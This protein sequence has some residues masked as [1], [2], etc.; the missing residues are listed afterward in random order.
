ML[1]ALGSFTDPALRQKALDLMLSGGFDP[2]E[3]VSILH[4]ASSNPDSTPAVQQFVQQ[5]YVALLDKLPEDSGATLPRMGRAL[6]SAEE[7]NN[8]DRFLQDPC[9][10]ISRRQAQLRA[11][12]REHRYLRDE[13][14]YTEG[15]DAAF[16]GRCR[17]VRYG[18]TQ[19]RNTSGEFRRSTMSA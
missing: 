1:S 9:R 13:P 18:K 2:R 7:R 16:Y 5:H 17:A 11:D 6:C 15:W 12:S 19:R 10:K 3:A 4:T 14:H 8:F